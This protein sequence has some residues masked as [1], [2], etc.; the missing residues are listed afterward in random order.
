MAL[1][2]PMDS[3]IRFFN[4]NTGTFQIVRTSR[5]IMGAELTTANSRNWKYAWEVGHS[6]WFSKLLLRVEDE[7]KTTHFWLYFHNKPNDWII[8]LTKSEMALFKV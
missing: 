1:R 5:P 3:P 6:N 4:M 2:I 7:L 8:V